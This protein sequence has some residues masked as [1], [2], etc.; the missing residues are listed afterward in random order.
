M[1]HMPL[2]PQRC[3]RP[4]PDTVPCAQGLVEDAQRDLRGTILTALRSTLGSPDEQRVHSGF[5]GAYAA[6]RAEVLALLDAM[7]AGVRRTLPRRALGGLSHTQSLCVSRRRAAA[8][9]RGRAGGDACVCRPFTSPRTSHPC[10]HHPLNPPAG[11][12][13]PWTLYITG[14]SLGGALSTLC[15]ADCAR[16][17]W[18]TTPARPS[19]VHY[20][21]GS[22]RVGNRAFA[23]EVLR[24]GGEGEE[25]AAGQLDGQQ[26]WVRSTACPSSR[27]PPPP[28]P[29]C[30]S[31][32][33]WC[34]TP[35]GW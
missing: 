33:S 11:D 8:A 27:L 1:Q 6:I 2:R 25:G 19:I 17:T 18:R 28:P 7:V 29:I 5:L 21:Y 26:C 34:P 4:V 23:E 10:P 30:C 15:A 20:S 31:S 35:G 13:E 24:R 12:A 22:P 14:H 32:T 3:A 16:R 9:A